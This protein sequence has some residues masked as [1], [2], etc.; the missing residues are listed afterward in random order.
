[1]MNDSLKYI[2]LRNLEILKELSDTEIDFLSKRVSHE[3]FFKGGQVYDLDDMVDQVYI[4]EKGSIKVGKHTND[5]KT[6]IKEMIYDGMI[7]GE[8]IFNGS[9]I[10]GEFA[11]AHMTCSV[12]VIPEHIFKTLLERNAAFCST[13]TGNLL[14]KLGK[15]EQRIQNFIFK[16]A[17]RR[18]MDFLKKAAESS[19][20][21]IGFEEL[22]VNHGMSHKEIAYLTDTSRQ[23]VARVLGELK[24]DDIIHFTARK[25]N[26]ILIRS[27]Q[28][29]S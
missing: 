11:E 14:E 22:L 8:N 21:K 10:R 1:M 9:R 6:L 17:K 19:G 24:N 15:L 26:K 16:K 28:R 27:I 7:F 20:I 13:I 18:I 25:P 5:D 4:L 2:T 3:K 23:T 12:F 29:L